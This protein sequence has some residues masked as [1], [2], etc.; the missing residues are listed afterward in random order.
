[1]NARLTALAVAIAVLACN[2]PTATGTVQWFSDAQGFGMIAPDDSSGD[3]FVQVASIRGAT[4]LLPG[5]RVQFV[6]SPG[7]KGRQATDVRPATTGQ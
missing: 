5:Q 2:K 4:T 6:I 3:I 7:G 1:M